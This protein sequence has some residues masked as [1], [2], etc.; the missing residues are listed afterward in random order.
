MQEQSQQHTEDS[1][2]EEKFTDD[3]AKIDLN[4]R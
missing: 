3:H 4:D 1:S 2:D